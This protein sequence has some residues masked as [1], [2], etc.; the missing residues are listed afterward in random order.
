MKYRII[1]EYGLF[2]PQVEF[3]FFLWRAVEYP[4]NG[5]HAESDALNA[6]QE[7]NKMFGKSSGNGNIV[8]TGELK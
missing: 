5:Y 2:Y 7:H 3:F 1:K 4:D 6:I 8:W